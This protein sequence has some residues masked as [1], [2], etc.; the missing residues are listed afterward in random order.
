MYEAYNMKHMKHGNMK[1][2]NMKLMKHEAGK[3]WKHE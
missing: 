1:H 2:G 3:E